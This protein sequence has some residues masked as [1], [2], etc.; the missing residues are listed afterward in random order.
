MS[1]PQLGYR[2]YFYSVLPVSM[3]SNCCA[4]RHLFQLPSTRLAGLNFTIFHLSKNEE[5]SHGLIVLL[6]QGVLEN[7]FILYNLL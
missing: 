6:F 2:Q 1:V 7:N 3:S 5:A 4:F